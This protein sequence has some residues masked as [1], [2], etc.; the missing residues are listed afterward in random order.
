MAPFEHSFFFLVVA[1]IRGPCS[2]DRRL[3]LG[4]YRI[5]HRASPNKGESRMVAGSCTSLTALF[6]ELLENGASPYHIFSSGLDVYCQHAAVWGNA[7]GFFARER[8]RGE[9]R[10]AREK[11]NVRC[12]YIQILWDRSNA[13]N[14]NLT[15]SMSM[16]H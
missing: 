4:G 16:P 9:Q 3:P 10:K 14:T 1:R 15:Q 2:N 6:Q 8:F 5:F 12:W 13:V 11:R 7:R